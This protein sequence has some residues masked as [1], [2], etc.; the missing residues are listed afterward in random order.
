[1]TWYEAQGFY[2]DAQAQ[3]SWYDSGLTSDTLGSLIRSNDGKGQAYSLEVGKR[4]KVGRTL[5]VTPQL[6]MAYSTVDFDRFT[7][8]AKAV[9]SASLADSLK[10][11]TGIS[12]DYQS[13]LQGKTG[14]T[15]LYAVANVTFEWLDGTRTAVS[16]TDIANRDQRLWGELGVGGSHNLA[17]GKIS[18]Y[19]EVSANTALKHF[20]DSNALKANVGAR[21]RF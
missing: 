1:M 9:I 21:I 6:Q 20:G 17:D 8:P 12:I 4:A 11:R 15:H 19:G 5:T 10:S 7:D 3:I 2:A 14:Q 16:G 18:L 13:N